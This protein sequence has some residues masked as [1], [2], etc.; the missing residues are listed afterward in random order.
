MVVVGF[1]T[2][3]LPYWWLLQQHALRRH[4]IVLHG[5]FVAIGGILL[6]TILVI[7]L[8]QQNVWNS[9]QAEFLNKIKIA[10]NELQNATM[11]VQSSITVASMNAEFVDTLVKKDLPRLTAN[12]KIIYESNPDIRRLVFWI[13]TARV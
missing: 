4:K 8:L 13:K 10:Q 9:R 12:A 2:G 5:I 6:V 11:S 3:L 7:S 1:F